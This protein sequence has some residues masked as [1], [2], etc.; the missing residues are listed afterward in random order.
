MRL[1]IQEQLVLETTADTV[2]LSLIGLLCDQ[3]SGQRNSRDW[4]RLLDTGSD[5]SGDMKLT[6]AF[7]LQA[8]PIAHR[9]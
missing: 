8:V 6:V 2:L 4:G 5:L 9:A 7:G 3:I 1:E